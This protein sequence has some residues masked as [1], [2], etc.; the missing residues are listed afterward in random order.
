MNLEILPVFDHLGGYI[1]A[2]KCGSADIEALW[3]KHAITPYWPRLSK[4]APFDISDR[5]PRPVTD[6]DEL[7]KRIRLLKQL[8]LEELK[9]AF[10]K[11]AAVLPDY[12][13][14]MYIALYPL[15]SPFVR[16]RQ[17]GVWGNGTWGHMIINID[18]LGYEYKK[19]IPY[20]FAHEYHHN[21]WGNYWFNVH[22]GELEPVFLND[23]LSDGLADSYALSLYPYLHPEWLFSL[24]EEAV[25][26]LWHEHYSTLLLQSGVDYPK[27]M[28]GDETAGIPWCAG[29]A[30]SFRIVQYY[31]K[32]FPGTGMTELLHMRPMDIYLKSGYPE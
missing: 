12:D 8:D 10:Q 21:I 22:R 28:F 13:D 25:N 26:R 2:L 31:L 14:T 27:Y 5:K 29:Y 7:E 19:W 6:A 15:E 11:A 32:K 24:S 18:P 1:E 9:A 20:V 30:V 3:E 16:D 23:I 17:N 4:Y